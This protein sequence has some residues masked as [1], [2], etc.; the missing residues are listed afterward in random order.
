MRTIDGLAIYTT[1]CLGLRPACSNL[2]LILWPSSDVWELCTVL[3]YMPLSV[4]IANLFFAS[5]YHTFRVVTIFENPTNSADH[6]SRHVW[7]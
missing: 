2:S 5:S 3:R 7:N 6:N 4:A 1:G